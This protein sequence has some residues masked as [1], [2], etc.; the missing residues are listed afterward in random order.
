MSTKIL[1][2]EDDNALA[3][4]CAKL[5]RRCGHIALIASSGRDALAIVCEAR[6]IDIV[7]SDVQMPQ[8]TGVQLLDRLHALDATIPVILMTGYTNPL[9]PSQAFALGAA[10]YLMKPFDPE[11]LISSV[12]R[13][14]RTRNNLQHN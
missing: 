2:V 8:M 4:M 12:E 5:I 9:S 10:D 13:A 1:I 14:T 11:M 3:Q 7:I 6:D